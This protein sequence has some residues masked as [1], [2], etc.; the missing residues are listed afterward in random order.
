M[1]EL[2]RY[3]GRH[4]SPEAAAPQSDQT[5]HHKDASAAEPSLP[6][7]EFD[8]SATEEA[9]AA[10]ERSEHAEAGPPEDTMSPPTADQPGSDPT[11][12]PAERWPES[13]LS[14]PVEPIEPGAEPLG[15]EP[16]GTEPVGAEPE[17]TEPVGAE[18]EGTEPVGTDSLLDPS[19]GP[20]DPELPPDLE[21]PPEPFG[22]R[23]VS[24][25]PGAESSG[26]ESSSAEWAGT[27]PSGSEPSATEPSA[28]EPSEPPP[29]DLPGRLLGSPPFGPPP[30]DLPG[31]LGPPSS[32]PPGPEPPHLPR[33]QAFGPPGRA[34]SGLPRRQTFGSQPPPGPAGPPGRSDPPPSPIRQD[35]WAGPNTEPPPPDD[36]DGDTFEGT[37]DDPT[38]APTEAASDEH[39]DPEPWT[40]PAPD[41]TTGPRLVREGRETE[42][43]VEPSSLSETTASTWRPEPDDEAAAG[44]EL[45]PDPEPPDPPA[46]PFGSVEPELD[47]DPVPPDPPPPLFGSAESAPVP[48]AA[49]FGPP[50]PAPPLAPDP[51]SFGSDPDDSAEPGPRAPVLPD[52]DSHGLGR[53]ALLDA[54]HEV[55]PGGT[56][57]L[58]GWLASNLD[59]LEDP[60]GFT[61][62]QRE[63]A[64]WEPPTPAGR[65]Y[66]ADR[67]SLDIPGN[68]VTADLAGA[69]VLVRAQADHADTDGL[70]ALLSAAAAAQAQ[71]AVWVCPRIDE[72]LRQALR[73]IG[74]D[75][76]ANVRLYGLEMYL[77]RI[78]GSPTAPLFDAVVSPGAP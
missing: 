10:I 12:D 38:D 47:P 57:D 72:G 40:A 3:I 65:V 45:D 4:A 21:P 22:P 25:P 74:G 55:W 23:R 16:R 77:V 54:I 60:L 51:P 52:I 33:R 68:L 19:S 17:G 30:A 63:S 59:L 42:P 48:P 46:P 13:P 5:S 27:E 20:P 71:T 14:D 76:S 2:P 31:L 34:P 69:V 41:V 35:P 39:A 18:P 50:E 43:E 29:S 32:A 53:L 73:W 61:L 64:P 36:A 70:G 78:G 56:T 11:P 37:F 58:S 66:D 44:P 6:R 49:S 67:S 24:D 26:A 9:T 75:P 15:T 1:T 7:L 28:A 62:T 8:P